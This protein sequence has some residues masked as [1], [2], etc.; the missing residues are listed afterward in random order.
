MTGVLD[1]TFQLNMWLVATDHE[2]G[3][4]AARPYIAYQQ[5]FAGV[6]DHT[7]LSVAYQHTDHDWGTRPNIAEKDHDRSTR[8]CWSARPCIPVEYQDTDRD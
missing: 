6:L 2:C 4:L 8:L 1:H 3:V 7:F 5:G